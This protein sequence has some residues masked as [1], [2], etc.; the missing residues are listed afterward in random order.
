MSGVTG[1]ALAYV[2]LASL[3]LLAVLRSDIRPVTK[4]LLVIAC[5]GFYLWHFQAL[6]AWRGWPASDLLPQNFELIDSVTVEPD[7]RRGEPGAIYVWIRD[8]DADTPLPR[9]Y[10]FDYDKS[11]H[12]QVDDSLR[13]QREGRYQVGSPRPGG[14]INRPRVDFE[15]VTRDTRGLKGAGSGS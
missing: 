4:L 3:L 13:K 14:S 11:L 6:Q 8:L 15:E 9:A 5:A 1:I 10:R 12:R 7:L 2:L